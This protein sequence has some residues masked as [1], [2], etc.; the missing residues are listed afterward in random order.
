MPDA[1]KYILISSGGEGLHWCR[2]VLPR[3]QQIG[4]ATCAGIA[5]INLNVH[6]AAQEYLGLDKD[7]CFTEP[8]DALEKRLAD[9]S[10]ILSPPNTHE[11]LMELS[12]IQAHDVLVDSP[13]AD[14]MIAACRIYRK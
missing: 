12:L 3:L 1:R 13:I 6:S 9:F 10:I 2:N 11:K 8:A 7:S 5:D 4:K 14:S